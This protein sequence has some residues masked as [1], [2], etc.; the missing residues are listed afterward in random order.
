MTIKVAPDVI[1]M[2]WWKDHRHQ[3]PCIAQLPRKL[4][5]VTATSTP[6]KR[7][8]SYCGL[9]LTARCS[10]LKGNVLPDQVMTHQNAHCL[11]ITEDV[12]KPNSQ[13]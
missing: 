9:A 3:F 1:P 11:T 2:D 13:K 7:V 12:S 6:Y 8:F 5:C 10:R 4:L